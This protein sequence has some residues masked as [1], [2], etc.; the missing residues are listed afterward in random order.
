[1]GITVDDYRHFVCIVAGEKPEE[2]LHPYDGTVEVEP[3]I[4]YKKKDAEKLQAL[5]INQYG[6]KIS[7]LP[8]DDEEADILQSALEDLEELSPEEFY[9]RLTRQYLIDEKTG[10][11][12]STV[13]KQGKFR[14]C[15]IG[16]MFSAPFLTIDGKSVYQ[17]RK[18]EI[19]WDKV[20][21]GDDTVYR[22]AWEMVMEKSEPK[23]KRDKTIFDNMKD[24]VSYFNKFETKENYINSC[25]SFWGWAFLSDKTGWIDASKEQSQ[26]NWI[27][28]FFDK[29]IKPLPDDALLSI[30]ECHI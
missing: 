18:R 8:E 13:N 2:I 24:K 1:M 26:F 21:R 5:F 22:R 9:K 23:D 12:M 4:V 11:A 28:T 14:Y 30:Y 20:H 15:N 27:E 10:N 19:D 3:Y 17:A 7:H 29:F 25:T 6:E 16:K